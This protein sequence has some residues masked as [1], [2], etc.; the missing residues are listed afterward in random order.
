MSE[1]T[2]KATKT[3]VVCWCGC[4]GLTKSRFVPGHDARHH[5][6]AKRLAR[7]EANGENPNH[8]AVWAALPHDAAI[9]DF[10]AHYEAE[11]PRATAKAQEKAAKAAQKAAEKAAKE[12]AKATPTTDSQPATAETPAVAA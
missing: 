1:T 4:G 5:G 2:T 11:L 8:E 3:P 6:N 9:D 10:V 7:A 12:A